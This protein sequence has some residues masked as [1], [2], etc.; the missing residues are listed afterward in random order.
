MQHSHREVSNND[1]LPTELDE[2]EYCSAEFDCL[3]LDHSFNVENVALINCATS[4]KGRLK[5]RLAF[6][7]DTGAS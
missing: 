2:V 1:V 4:V 7:K 5:E 3:N 6:W